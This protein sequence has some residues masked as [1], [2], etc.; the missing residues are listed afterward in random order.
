MQHLNLFISD[1]LLPFLFQNEHLNILL[2]PLQF[3]PHPDNLLILSP[4]VSLHLLNKHPYLLSP[5]FIHPHY[6]FI[7]SSHFLHCSLPLDCPPPFLFLPV[8]YLGYLLLNQ[9]DDRL[10]VRQLR[11]LPCS[12][13]LR[14]AHLLS[15]QLNFVL[16]LLNSVLCVVCTLAV[17]L[18]LL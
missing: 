8:L 11:A 15:Q 14:L 17:P 9:F 10:L 1:P 13:L 12:L 16:E 4:L 6:L 18:C 7:L 2:S 3:L 5:L